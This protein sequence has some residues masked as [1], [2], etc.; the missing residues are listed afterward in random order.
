MCKSNAQDW[1]HY[2]STA[3]LAVNYKIRN[4]PNSPL[5]PLMYARTI[6]KIKDYNSEEEIKQ[7]PS[8]YMSEE[9]LMKKIKEMEKMVFPEIKDRT[10]RIIEE[11]SKNITKEK[12]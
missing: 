5:F 8:H 4:R 9:E 2:L 6:N 3:Q 11:Y 12:C 1:D 10:Q 7:M